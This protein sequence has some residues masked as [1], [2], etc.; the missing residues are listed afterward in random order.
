MK[1]RRF[2]EE[3]IAFADAFVA[4]VNKHH[5]EH[6]ALQGQ[7]AKELAQVQRKLEGLI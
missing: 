3:Q 4:E 1:K 5:R 7:R 2:T 6:Q